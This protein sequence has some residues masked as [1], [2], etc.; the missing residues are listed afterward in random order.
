M[1]GKDIRKYIER[2]DEE[3]ALLNESRELVVCGGAAMLFGNY[4]KAST[5]DIDMLKPVKD[6]VLKEISKKLA[7]EFEHLR[8]NWLNSDSSS[9]LSDSLPRDWELR[10]EERFTG[11]HLRVLSL[12]REDLL[13]S[14][15]CA[16]IDREMDEDDI[17][18]LVKGDLAMFKRISTEVLQTKRFGGVLGQ[19]IVDELKIKLEL[20]D[21]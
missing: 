5:Q 10:L 8:D 19:T 6:P 15:L 4:N 16:H 13:Y 2:I 3:L 20:G 1:I 21:E 18:E 12:G 17:R 9:F 14:K 7:K 11:S